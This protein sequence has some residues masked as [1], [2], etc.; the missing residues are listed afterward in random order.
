MQTRVVEIRCLNF[1]AQDWV[2]PWLFLIRSSVRPKL[3]SDLNSHAAP[4]LFSKFMKIFFISESFR[5]TYCKRNGSTIQ[6]RA[7]KSYYTP[8]KSQLS[9]REHRLYW[10]LL[11]CHG[12][13]L[14]LAM[15]RASRFIRFSRKLKLHVCLLH[16]FK[17]S[18]RRRQM[19]RQFAFKLISCLTRPFS[20]LFRNIDKAK[21]GTGKN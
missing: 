6:I 20:S 3:V 11:D 9:R 5:K 12:S 18:K 8:K 2:V 17:K 1:S 13:K 10:P 7:Q 16:V 21:T 4:L 14:T 15:S 19:E